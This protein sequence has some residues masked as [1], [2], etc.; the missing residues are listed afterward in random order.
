MLNNEEFLTVSLENGLFYL[1]TIREFCANIKLAFL[2][3]N[4][5]Y[6]K[7][8]EGFADRCE[9]LGAIL[10]K[11]A[12][13]N[14]SKKFLDSKSIVTEY[15]LPS[16]L[17]TEKLF[18][19]D[20][21]TDITRNELVLKPGIPGNI[22]NEE[23]NIIMEVNKKALTLTQEFIEYLTDIFEK[24]KKL[25]LFS[26]SYPALIKYMIEETKLYNSYLERLIRKEKVDPSFVTDYQYMFI[27]SMKD[28]ASFLR[29]MVNPSEEEFY[30]KAESF[31]VEFEHLL[32]EYKSTALSPD[33]QE[34]LTTKTL[35]AVKR[36]SDY[37]SNCIKNVLDSKLY[38]IVEP[39]FL[40]N[41]Y[42]EANYFIY[43]LENDIANEIRYY[44]GGYNVN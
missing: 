30:I 10:T 17:L 5:E 32:N 23:V 9:E 44:W 3:K 8:A 11:Y 31:Y 27:T 43:I 14:L 36:F 33:L 16:E 25:E 39:I 29:S 20:I 22:T 38:Y 41:L 34:A 4:I 26:Y 15:T 12:D 35:K 2:N 24:E 28:A 13:G 37:I 6:S 42:T 21:N 18:G 40:D 1:R 19:I 7:K